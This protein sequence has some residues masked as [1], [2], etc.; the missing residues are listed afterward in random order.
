MELHEML[1]KMAA[2]KGSDLYLSTGSRPMVRVNN[3]LIAISE[4]SLKLGEV[5]KFAYSQLNSEQIAV[6]ENKLEQNLSVSLSGI[7]R[8]RV[9]IFVQRGEVGMVIR[10]IMTYI[11]NFKELNLPATLSSVAMEKRGLVLIVGSTGSGKSTTV[12]SIIDYINKNRSGHVITIEDPIEYIHH[13]QGCVINQRE[14]GIDTLS[15]EDALKNAL[16][17]APDVIVIGEIRSR[18]TMDQAIA[19]AETGHLCISTLHANNANQAL[20]RIINFFPAD[21]HRQLLLDL[22][23]NLKLI[24]SQRL[25][26]AL[27]GKRL[28]AYEILLGSPLVLDLIYRDEIHLIKETME[29]STDSGMMTFDL[30][31]EKLYREHKISLEEA[32][33][34][35]DSKNNLRLRLNMSNHE[36]VSTQHSGKKGENDSNSDLHLVD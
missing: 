21:R 5:K 9:N 8:F 32:L 25:V 22:S 18:E 13:H 34:N 19:F 10:H 28:P 30:S 1:H 23:F 3:K 14:V 33:L 4:E 24:F 7:G 11:P 2:I 16:R 15:Y 20:D 29:K 12:A 6:F 31:L 35:A 17:Q 36:K 26:S 27:D